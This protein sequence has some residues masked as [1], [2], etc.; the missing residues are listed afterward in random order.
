MILY[1]FIGILLCYSFLIV[2]LIKGFNRLPVFTEKKQPKKQFSVAIPFRNEA[3]NLPDLLNSILNINYPKELFEIL[4]VNDESTDGST[5]IITQFKEENPAIQLYLL[6]NNRHTNSP[7]KDAISTAIKQAKFD[8]ILTTDADCILPTTW[9][10]SFNSFILEKDPYMVVAPVSLQSNKS[11]LDQFQL[12]DFLSMQGST[13]GGFGI[14]KAFMAN[15]ANLGY[16]KEIFNELNGFKNN[17]QI[18][19]GDDVFLL[20]DFL[21]LAPKKVTFLKTPEALVITKP[22]ANW[23]ELINQRRRWAAKSQ[24]FKSKFTKAVGLLVFVTNIVVI[25]L[26]LFSFLNNKLITLI[27]IKWL[28]DA[29]LIFK[30]LKFYQQKTITANY[31]ATILLHPFFTIYIAFTSLFFS[32]KWKERL[33]KK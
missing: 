22:V 13:I 33:F 28:V 2:L 16:K 27:L 29:L 5:K 23:K 1:F 25:Y 8:W 32:Y 31:L 4:L 11:F 18:A 12:I 26:Y 3:E 14:N 20:E 24:H 6:D 21:K 10:N 19:S 17:S 7:K 30:T 15:G 9:L